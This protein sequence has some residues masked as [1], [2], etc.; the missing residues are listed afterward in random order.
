[1]S[2]GLT[3]TP[4]VFMDLMNRVFKKYL[5]LFVFIFLDDILICSRNEEEHAGHLRII[6]LTLKIT[7]YLLT[8]ANMSSG[9]NQLLSFVTLYLERRFEWICRR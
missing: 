8:L 1:M 7:N 4:V 2:L 6:L 3:N 9:Y 5:D